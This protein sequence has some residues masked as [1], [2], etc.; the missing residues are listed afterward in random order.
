M[1]YLPDSI[2]DVSK[3]RVSSPQWDTAEA[4]SRPVV[5]V[6]VVRGHRVEGLVLRSTQPLDRLLASL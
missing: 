1:H 5:S 4:G 6:L 3:Y 2:G